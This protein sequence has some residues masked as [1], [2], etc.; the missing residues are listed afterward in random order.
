MTFIVAAGYLTGI[1]LAI[2]WVWLGTKIEWME[3]IF[4]YPL[5][6]VPIFLLYGIGISREFAIAMGL[7]AFVIYPPLLIGKWLIALVRS[8]PDPTIDDAPDAQA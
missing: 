6:L 7:S 2:G 1:C 3:S 8:K 5:I 4:A